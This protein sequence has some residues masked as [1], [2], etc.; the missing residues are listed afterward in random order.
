MSKFIIITNETITITLSSKKFK[1]LRDKYHK[2]WIAFYGARYEGDT[3]VYQSH[4][5]HNPSWVKFAKELIRKC[6]G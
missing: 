3:L 2:R 6:S 1:K 5:N 4:L